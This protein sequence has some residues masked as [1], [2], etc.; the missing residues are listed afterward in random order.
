MF[1]LIDSER[2]HSGADLEPA[3]EAFLATCR[4]AD[5]QCFITERRATENYFTEDAIKKAF[6]KFRA[7][8]EFEALKEM[9]PRWRKNENWRIA[10]RMTLDELRDTDVHKVFTALASA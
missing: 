10:A 2:T 3:R 6:G 9:T 1:A 7:L 4:G 8:R 5:I